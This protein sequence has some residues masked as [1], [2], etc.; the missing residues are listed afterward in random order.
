M[1]NVV[2]QW[3]T[4]LSTLQFD[5]L[6][7]GLNRKNALVAMTPAADLAREEGVRG[8]HQTTLHARQRSFPS[9]VECGYCRHTLVAAG[10]SPPANVCWHPL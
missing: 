5:A 8:S 7:Y 10:R 9:N 4:E 1:I 3:P 2:I 6:I